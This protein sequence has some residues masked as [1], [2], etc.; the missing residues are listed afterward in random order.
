MTEPKEGAPLLRQ[1]IVGL[2]DMKATNN[3]ATE[4]ATYALGSCLAVAIYD[5]KARVGGLLHFMLPDSTIDRQRA[6][7]NPY[8]FADTGIPLLFR[9]AYKLGAVKERIIC[10]LAG[11]ASVMDPDNCL[12][13]A[14]LNHLAATTVLGKNGVAPSGEYIGGVSGISL[15]LAIQTGRVTVNLPN[16]SELEL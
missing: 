13:I 9:R 4:L 5:P 11:A 14:M 10:K 16:G 8:F 3:P 1:A 15:T 12:N 6:L 2:A 7:A